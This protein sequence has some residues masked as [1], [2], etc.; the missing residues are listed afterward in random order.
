ME[1]TDAP[2]P[3]FFIVATCHDTQKRAFSLAQELRDANFRGEVAFGVTGL[4]SLM[5]QAHKSGARW[6]LIIGRDEAAASAATLK[7]MADGSQ[8]FVPLADISSIF[9][10]NRESEH[11]TIQR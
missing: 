2:V 7:N 8:T 10:H 1:K 5:R 4:K 11:D 6:C 3:D 9:L